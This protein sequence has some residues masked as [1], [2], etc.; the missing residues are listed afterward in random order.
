MSVDT[1]DQAGARGNAHDV[2][3]LV[4]HAGKAGTG[5]VGTPAAIL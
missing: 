1:D 4:G 3:F 5:L 2:S